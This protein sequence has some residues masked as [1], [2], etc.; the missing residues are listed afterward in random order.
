MSFLAPQLG[1]FKSQGK[2]SMDQSSWRVCVIVHGKGQINYCCQKIY[3]DQKNITMCSLV[4]LMA[5]PSHGKDHCLET[6]SRELRDGKQTM[7]GSSHIYNIYVIYIIYIIINNIY[8]NSITQSLWAMV[9]PSH[10]PIPNHKHLVRFSFS[11]EN[12]SQP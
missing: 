3:N 6:T 10:P 7:K 5:I 9:T 12:P 8:N 4:G 11:W 2:S 1:V